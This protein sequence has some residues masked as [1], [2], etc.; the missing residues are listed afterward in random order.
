MN[1]LQM[2]INIPAASLETVDEADEGEVAIVTL[3]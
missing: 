1:E 2:N 3:D